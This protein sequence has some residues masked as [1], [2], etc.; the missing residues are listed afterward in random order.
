MNPSPTS[1]CADLLC[2]RALTRVLQ[3]CVILGVAATTPVLRA[4][5]T[6]LQTKDATY[7]AFEAEEAALIAGTP[8][9]WTV[10]A[11]N[12]ASGKAALKIAGSNSTGDSP[13]SFA[14]YRIKFATEGT[15]YIYYRWLADPVLAFN[16]NFTANSIWI[17]NRF[18]AFSTPGAAAQTDYV[19]SDSNNLNFP[20][21]SVYTWRRDVG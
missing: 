14:Q 6:V 5:S 1:T 8:E 17:A 12:A 9:N 7:V 4:A 19:R 18:G 13:H 10:Y 2:R 15:Y 11:D 16:D 3:Y 20:D 21:N